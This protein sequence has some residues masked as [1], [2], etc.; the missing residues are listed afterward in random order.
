MIRVQVRKAVS[1]AILQG[2]LNNRIHPRECGD[3]FISNVVQSA[4]LFHH[5]ISCPHAVDIGDPWALR[6][7][8]SDLCA[9]S[10]TGMDGDTCHLPVD[11]TDAGGG[12]SFVCEFLRR[13]YVC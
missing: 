12:V 9:T 10:V 1:F 8:I 6:P 13:K 2:R 3:H 11:T 7:Q 4:R 5:F